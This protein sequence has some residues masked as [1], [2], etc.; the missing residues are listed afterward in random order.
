MSGV[1]YVFNE[2]L[3]YL[4]DTFTRCQQRASRVHELVKCSGLLQ[5]ELNISV[6]NP[7]KGTKNDLSIFHDADFVNFLTSGSH[8]NMDENHFLSACE[9]FGLEFECPLA[10]NL[11]W[12]SFRRF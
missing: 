12:N 2:R 1:V 4:S 5:A 11:G 7:T 6:L 10:E 3:Q 8:Q 9:L